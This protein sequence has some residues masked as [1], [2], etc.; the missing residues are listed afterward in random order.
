MTGREERRATPCAA[1]QDEGSD[2]AQ[3]REEP[4]GHPGSGFFDRFVFD[5]GRLRNTLFCMLTESYQGNQYS[6][7]SWFAG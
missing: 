3:K 5:Y 1:L 7:V 4:G 6:L 2:V